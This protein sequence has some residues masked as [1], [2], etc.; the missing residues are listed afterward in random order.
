MDLTTAC[1][2][3]NLE[4]VKIILE[5]LDKL[6]REAVLTTADANTALPL[7]WAALNGRTDIVRLLISC[8]SNVNALAGD[9]QAPALHWAICKGH[10]P[11]IAALIDCGADWR[12]SDKQGYNAVHIAAQNGQMMALL[13]LIEVAGADIDTRD[14]FG[15]T[16]LLWA[17]YK[18]HDEVVDLLLTLKADLELYDDSLRGPLHWAVAKDHAFVAAKLMKAG[19]RAD[20][21]DTDKKTPADWAREKDLEWYGRLEQLAVETRLSPQPPLKKFI[22]TMILPSLLPTTLSAPFVLLDNGLVAWIAAGVSSFIVYKTAGILLKVPLATTSFLRNFNYSMTSSIGWVYFPWI[23]PAQFAQ[24]PALSLLFVSSY[25]LVICTLFVLRRGDS[26]IIPRAITSSERHSLL[27]SLAVHDQLDRRRFCITCRQC[28]PLRSK[29]CRSC[30][31]CVGRFDHHCPWIETCIGAKNHRTFWAYVAGCVGV[32]WSAAALGYFFIIPHNLSPPPTP[33]FLLRNTGLCSMAS[34]SPTAF[35]FTAF[36]GFS[37]FWL[38]ILFLIQSYQISR[39]LTTNEMSNYQRLEYFFPEESAGKTD[40]PESA[41]NSI[42][43]YVNPFDKGFL[44][45]WQEFWHR[46]RV[47]DWLWQLHL[48]SEDWERIRSKNRKGKHEIGPEEFSP[49]LEKAGIELSSAWLRPVSALSVPMNSVAKEHPCRDHCCQELKTFNKQQQGQI[50]LIE[51]N[52]RSP[53]LDS[54]LHLNIV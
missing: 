23:L 15:R 54:S 44:A 33:C 34:F 10:L 31:V 46:T 17:A 18:G 22:A 11:A 21:R 52:I 50:P 51:S 3:G 20:L 14:G 47:S 1:Q 25:A 38:T 12:L 26:G 39:N 8:G 37:G 28:K 13:Y 43:K 53:L 30:D 19:A 9:Q 32:A 16:P 35:W 6:E 45:N 24:Q 2:Q 29:H 41:S 48:N 7:H 4:Q 27:K 49:C 40:A 5:K 42:R 36:T